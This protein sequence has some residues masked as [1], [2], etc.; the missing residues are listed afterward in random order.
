MKSALNKFTLAL[1][2]ILV[3]TLLSGTAFAGCGDTNKSKPGTSLLPQSWRGQSGSFLPISAS[4][5][6]D[7]IVGLWHATFT[8]K[9][10]EQGPPD[11]TPIDNALVTWHGDHTEIIASARPPKDG[12]ICLGVWGK[13]GKLTYKL[14][15]IAW[16]AND[17]ANAPSGIGNPT[18]PV[19]I[20]QE[21]TLS[22]D[23]KH[24]TGR[25]TLD[26][27]DTSGNDVAHIVGVLL[28]T[29]ITLETTV[30]DLL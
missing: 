3:G 28:G 17:T 25:F 30:P 11:G 29:R 16:F 7:P 10:N 12:D 20:F 19:R 22:P 13:T 23:G 24:Y 21:I 15:H 9:G 26:A 27:Y 14:N 5:S 8:A 6:D 18:G 1:G 2:I 4:S